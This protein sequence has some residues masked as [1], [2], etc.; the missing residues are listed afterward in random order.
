MDVFAQSGFAV[1]AP[2][3]FARKK[4]PKSCDPVKK[5]GGLYRAVLK[6]RQL[7]ALHAIREARKLSW[8]DPDNIFLMG[9]SEGGIVSA[10][11]S[12]ESGQSVRA[13]VIEGWTCRAGWPEY[14]TA[15]KRL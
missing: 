4:Y 11:L 9:F 12:I 15:R 10:T 5:I 13:R 8:V 6:M 14:Q 3:S 7:D 1:I 2:A